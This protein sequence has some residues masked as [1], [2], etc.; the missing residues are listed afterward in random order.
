M[1]VLKSN[2][3]KLPP[4][5]KYCSLLFDEM[6]ISAELHYNEH[7]DGIEGFEDYGYERTQKFANHALV[8]MVRG[9]TK[10]YKQPIAYFFCQGSTN[11]H[12]LSKIIKDV[13]CEVYSTGLHVVATI[14]HQGA[15]NEAAINNLHSVTKAHYLRQ[16]KEYRDDMY[17]IQ[18][19][20]KCFQIIHLF[21][22]PHLL[23]GN[24]IYITHFIYLL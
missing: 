19:N 23:K 16:N 12:R 7:L 20:N 4:S 1:K 18:S 3:E 9:I 13:I 5:Q 22:A 2:V 14:S 15:T 11:N 17:K 10:K 6:S 24:N 21:D 8:F